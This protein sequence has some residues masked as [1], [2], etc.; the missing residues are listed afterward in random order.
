MQSKFQL[1][2]FK[3]FVLGDVFFALQANVMFTVISGIFVP[4]LFMHIGQ[5]RVCLAASK[6]KVENKNKAKKQG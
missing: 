6:N 5:L 4:Y 2:N 1:T 3:F